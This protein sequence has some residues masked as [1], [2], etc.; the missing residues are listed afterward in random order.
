MGKRLN[1]INKKF[2]L[3]TVI[4]DVKGGW[5]CKCDCGNLI[6]R[7]SGSLNR[8]PGQFKSCGCVAHK[9]LGQIEP[10]EIVMLKKVYRAYKSHAKTK[11]INFILTIEEVKCLII[12]NCYYCNSI[13]QNQLN[14]K[15]KS[16]KTNFYYNGIDRVN[17]EI[18]YELNNSVPCCHKCNHAKRNWP[19]CDFKEWI[20]KIHSNIN[21]F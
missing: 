12:Q 6:T 7:E 1:L 3:L 17:N 19:L 9:N 14:H 11:N 15:N 8:R 5:I 13:P 18:G 21:N 4:S 20:Q 16:R 10:D 2:G